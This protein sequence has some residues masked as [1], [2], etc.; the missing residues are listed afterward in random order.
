M[1][2]AAAPG[3]WLGLLFSFRGRMDRRRFV[4]G[5]G[6][7]LVAIIVLEAYLVGGV[8][9]VLRG[10]PG[11]DD[12]PSPSDLAVV[13]TLAAAVLLAAWIQFAAYA[14]RFHDRGFSAFWAACYLA[15]VYGLNLAARVGAPIRAEQASL[16]LLLLALYAAGLFVVL[17]RSSRSERYGPAPAWIAD[18]S[19]RRPGW[20][21]FLLDL[22]LA[23]AP[24]GAIFLLRLFVMEPFIVPSG[25]MVPTLEVG[26]NF[27]VSKSGYGYSRFSI[28]FDL[29]SF[30][31]R[32]FAR[33][34]ERG[35]VVALRLP[36]D[37]SVIHVKRIVGLPGD[38]IQVREGLLYL[39]DQPV[40][41][42]PASAY[43]NE[44]Y[45]TARPTPQFVE[46]LPNGRSYRILQDG[47]N[48]PY[49]DTPVFEVPPGHVFALGD[50]RS[51]SMDSR[52][53]SAVGLIPFENLIGPVR[54]RFF[55]I[56]QIG[57]GGSGATQPVFMDR[58]YAKHPWQ[59]FWW[60]PREIRYSRL[61][62]AVE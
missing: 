24:L 60:W 37:P 1:P 59:E 35:D 6:I 52:A 44:E 32:V 28:P 50:N 14:K 30:P 62:T 2:L 33:L 34:P 39:N 36:R 56:R 38:R 57:E 43:V 55:S 21:A 45:G 25:G 27:F 53:L 49:D 7:A 8:A 48:G 47:T 22:L 31:G 40:A 19:L 3:T 58:S 12:G 20:G 13:S 17:G 11:D 4:V 15:G 26:D 51:N 18:P 9:S 46:T 16:G 5:P 29:A 54:Y 10:A 61:F 42:S 23:A 41:R